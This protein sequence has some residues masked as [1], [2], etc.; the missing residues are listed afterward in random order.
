[1]SRVSTVEMLVAL[2]LN[3][4][5]IEDLWTKSLMAKTRE[6]KRGGTT[7]TVIW[8]RWQISLKSI[9]SSLANFISCH[10]YTA[11]AVESSFFR[12][13]Y[14]CHLSR[15]SRARERLNLIFQN[16]DSAYLHVIDRAKI[17][18]AGCHTEAATRA[19]KCI[20]G[21]IDL[22]LELEI[23]LGRNF[24]PLYTFVNG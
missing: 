14:A 8:S 11:I 24:F 19:L 12:H 18:E 3:N 2:G 10:R 15:H 17:H 20:N 5:E 9:C 22:A 6:Q 4:I 21:Y 1:M 16:E 7:L 23:W 13:G